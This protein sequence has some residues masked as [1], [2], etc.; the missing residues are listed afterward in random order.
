MILIFILRL[1]IL[2][3]FAM[4]HISDPIPIDISLNLNNLSTV[5]EDKRKHLNLIQSNKISDDL[6]FHYDESGIE[7]LTDATELIQQN[8]TFQYHYLDEFGN[9]ITFVQNTNFAFYIFTCNES[10]CNLFDSINQNTQNEINIAESIS[11]AT[12][13][14]EQLTSFDENSTNNQTMKNLQIDTEFKVEKYSNGQTTQDLLTYDVFF[15]RD[16]SIQINQ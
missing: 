11:F 9:I 13:M 10:F 7:Q 1:M 14:P 3:E 6:L 4:V 16:I 5:I 8:Q 15:I 12:E 2:M